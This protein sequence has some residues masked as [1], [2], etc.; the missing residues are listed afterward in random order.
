MVFEMGIPIFNRNQGDIAAA[1]IKIDQNK[2]L[3]EYKTD[4]IKSEVN[5]AFQTLQQAIELRESFNTEITSEMEKLSENARI[6]FEKKNINLYEYIDYQRS[7]LEYKMNLIQATRNY[8][9]AINQLNF[10]VGT[11]IKKL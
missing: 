5:T 9:D 1:K 11:D 8:N 6:N 3:L 10:T 2:L 7:Y 4:E